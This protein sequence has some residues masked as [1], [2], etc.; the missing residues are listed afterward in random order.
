VGPLRG[1]RVVELAHPLT[2]WAGKLMADLGAD[3]IVV[4]PP[5]GSEQRTWGPFVD[6]EPGPE[7]SL[8]WWTYH[9]SKHSVVC[10]RH[11]EDDAARL[12][13]LVK[14]ADVLLAVEPLDRERWRGSD[15][16][17]VTVSVLA[18]DNATDL[19][20]LAAG[21]PLWMC[22]YDDHSAPP[23]RGEGNQAMHTVGHWATLGVLVALMHRE[24]S[25]R[26]Q[27]LDVSA[28]AALN[29]TTE[30]G[31]YAYLICGQ[32]VTR[33]T[34]RHASWAPTL[35]TQLRCA[36]GRYVNAGVAART[37]G[38]FAS[39]VAWLHDLGL[40]EAF[41]GTVFLQMGADRPRITASDLADP[42]V[43]QI[44]QTVREAQYFVAERV[45]AAEFFVTA[46]RRGL[47]AGVVYAPEDV[48][49][50]EHFVA[51]AWPTTVDQDGRSVTY[52]GPP[53]R[54]SHTPWAIRHPAP[55]L[56]EH[57]SRLTAGW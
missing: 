52:A 10:D 54:F 39:M 32:E 13:H 35:P 25:G 28:L 26:G 29:V 8:W 55:R 5:G 49:T 44:L 2:A 22:G 12:A 16:R 17:L 53:Y 38:E 6:D 40:A 9:T 45:N 47:T 34:G 57:Q 18:P 7:R 21:G 41:E 31:S 23:V 30:M 20:L 3:V 37:P 24:V 14:D 27:H 43:A 42:L 11:D 19:T 48:L 51:R 33:Q 1:V 15:D 56:G 4:E 36:D 46:Q 50:D